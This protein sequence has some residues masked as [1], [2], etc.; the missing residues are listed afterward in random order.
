MANSKVEKAAKPKRKISFSPHTYSILLAIVALTAVLTHVIPAGQYDRVFDEVTGRMVVDPASF[1]FIESTP[2]SLMQFLTAIPRGF[3]SASNVII[4]TIICGAAFGILNEIGV[5]NAVVQVVANK[6]KDNK[7]LVIPVLMIVFASIDTIIGTPELIIVYVSFLLPLMLRLGFDSITTLGVTYAA[8]SAGF[9]AGLMN[10]F[11]TVI[12]QKLSG[13]PLYSGMGFR[14]VAFIVGTTIAIL[15]TMRYSRRLLKDP[16]NSYVYEGDAKWREKYLVRGEDSEVAEVKL[17]GRQKIAGIYI[18]AVLAFMVYGM[19]SFGWDMNEM[20]ALF[21]VMGVGAGFI[22]GMNLKSIYDSL[23]AGGATMM[24]SVFVLSLAR[25]VSVMMSDGQITDTLVYWMSQAIGG[26][27]KA[28]CIIGVLFSV[29]ILEIFLGSGS[30]KAVILMPILS[31]LA[32]VLGITRQTMVLAFQFGD[33][34]FNGTMPDAPQGYLGLD[35]GKWLKFFLPLVGIQYVS[36]SIMLII[37]N[38]INYG[39]F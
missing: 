14:I 2:V 39:P 16:K 36:A 19:L 10:P 21:L 37:A 26:W 34:Y 35:W 24:F 12:S 32:D 15:Y 22:A 31:P 1:H 17:G 4:M 30:G 11:S 23:I 7:I 33:G 8:S 27:P 20:S 38:A 13:L 6:F 28:I 9:A 3:S 5:I 25:G 18:I 29:L